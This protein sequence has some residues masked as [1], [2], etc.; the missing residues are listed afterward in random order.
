MVETLERRKMFRTK[1][2]KDVNRAGFHRSS[3]KEPHLCDDGST[4]MIH[5]SPVAEEKNHLEVAY[6][7]Y[8]FAEDAT[9]PENL[10][11]KK[12]A[13]TKI[14]DY[15]LQHPDYKNKTFF[16]EKKYE[17]Y[18]RDDLALQKKKFEL[19][20]I[21]EKIKEKEQSLL[22]NSQSVNPTTSKKEKK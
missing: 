9:F 13:G 5:F 8:E 7:V 20:A 14:Y 12:L 10:K 18:Q 16:E 21:E 22:K 6:C 15:L 19:Q 1:H 4:F 3:I 17:E 11:D 2:Y